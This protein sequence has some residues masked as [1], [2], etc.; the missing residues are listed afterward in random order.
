MINANIIIKNQISQKNCR[1]NF[2]RKLSNSFE[3]EFKKLNP[4]LN[5]NS[6]YLNLFNKNYRFNLRLINLNKFKKFKTIVIIGMGGSILGT[7]AIHYFLSQKIKKKI[8]FFDDINS[9]KI[10]IFKKK[11]N[12]SKSLFIVISKSGNTIETLSNFFSLELIKKKYKKN[13]II[14]SE[15]K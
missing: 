3:K 13:I 12:L 11:E 6:E 14:I 2:L 7:Q 8:Y 9:N 1:Q 15:K 10:E 5:K 4:E